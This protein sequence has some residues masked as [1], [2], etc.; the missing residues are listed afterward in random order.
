MFPRFSSTYQ[1]IGNVPTSRFRRPD[2]FDHLQQRTTVTN[3][4]NQWCNNY[5]EK[6]LKI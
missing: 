5:Y 3:T 1:P 4:T 6:T 2:D